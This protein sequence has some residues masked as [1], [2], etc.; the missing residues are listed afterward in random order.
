[1]KRHAK[2]LLLL[3]LLCMLGASA[4]LLPVGDWLVF[5]LE[6]IDTHRNIAWAVYVTAYV[7]ASVLLIPGLILTL[8]AGF[9][10]GLPL[11]VALASTGSVLGA[12]AAFLV[13][14]FFARD[15]A[16]ERI[17]EMP[18]FRALDKAASQDGFVIVFLARLSPLF[19]F[20]L[21][22]YGLGVTSLRLR[23]YFFGS[24]IG[25]LPATVVFV[26][27]GTLAK[28]LTDLG[29]GQAEGGLAARGLLIAGFA[30]TVVLTFIVARKATR[31]LGAH[32]DSTPG[33]K[34]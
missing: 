16:A 13:G 2:P 18:R 17:T 20:N 6:W 4:F 21:M 5:S 32:L 22:N 33:P 28:D 9:L 29:T 11:G 27:L 19:P 34:T 3:A 25:M 24:W 14:R 26:Y 8:A 7:F 31:A 1:M 10:F 30:A 15:W 23:D 12:T